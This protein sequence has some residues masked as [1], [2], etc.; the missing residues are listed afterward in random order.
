MKNGTYIGLE[1]AGELDEDCYACSQGGQKLMPFPEVPKGLRVPVPCYHTLDV[2]GV[3]GFRVKT[4]NGCVGAFC[5]LGRGLNR[6]FC[7]LYK[8]RSEMARLTEAIVIQIEEQGYRVFKLVFD[9][10]GENI[11][12]EM[13]AFA[14]AYER[15]NSSVKPLFK[16]KPGYKRPH[17]DSAAELEL[18]TADLGVWRAKEV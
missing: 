7:Q 6:R 17:F 1:V 18:P 14:E 8:H 3:S 11:S 15:V 10:A 4:I 5:Y 13:I 12:D 9:N 2:D 16:K